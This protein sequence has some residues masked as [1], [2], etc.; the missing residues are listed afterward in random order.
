MLSFSY[1]QIHKLEASKKENNLKLI[2]EEAKQLFNNNVLNS[3]AY[4]KVTF[5]KWYQTI[6]LHCDSATIKSSDNIKSMLS[7]FANYYP[8]FPEAP[9]FSEILEIMTC[10]DL[11]EDQ[12]LDKINYRLLL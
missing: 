1:G 6:L 9:E 5:D 8:N 11:Q 7:Y 3:I 2:K 4:D 12:K 10:T